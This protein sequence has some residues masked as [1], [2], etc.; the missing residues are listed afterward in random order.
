MI[1]EIPFDVAVTIE[2]KALVVEN[3]VPS[4]H[5]WTI[6]LLDHGEWLTSIVVD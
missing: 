1:E 6:S 4:C 3:D 5:A 2:H